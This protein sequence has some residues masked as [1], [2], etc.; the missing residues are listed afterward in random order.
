MGLDMYLHAKRN[1]FDWDHSKGS[2]EKFADVLK[3]VLKVVGLTMDDVKLGGYLSAKIQV[4]VGYWRKANAIH[5]WFVENVQSGKD[6]C[7]PHY[8]DR[9]KL[10]E[11]KQVCEAVLLSKGN[12]ERIKSLLCP[13]SGF[14]FGSTEIDNYYFDDIEHTIKV[15]DLCLSDK[16]NDWTF[17]Y[18]SSW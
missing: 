5:K 11:L 7:K 13:T 16:F 2:T 17:E 18:V 1:V 12:E 8:V 3:D 10:K 4:S 6:E 15:I 9:S 14:F